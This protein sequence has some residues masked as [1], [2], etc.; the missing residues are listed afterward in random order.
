MDLSPVHWVMPL[1]Q[2]Q[3]MALEPRAPHAGHRGVDVL[4]SEGAGTAAIRQ[5]A[6]PPGSRVPPE[7]HRPQA[8]MSACVPTSARAQLAQGDPDMQSR[9]QPRQL[10]PDLLTARAHLEGQL[11]L[12]V[13]K[14]H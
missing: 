1:V 8:V 3:L 6:Q 2:C 9:G 12:R 13:D 4:V 11:Y 10:T 5:H 14:T 7:S